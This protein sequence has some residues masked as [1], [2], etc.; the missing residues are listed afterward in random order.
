[1]EPVGRSPWSRHMTRS[2]IEDRA[3]FGIVRYAQCWEDAD[4]LL[5]AL[6]VKPGETCLS[7]ASAGDNCLSLLARDPARVVAID[8]SL[9]QLYCLEL[10]VAAY[11]RLSHEQLLGLM[12]SRHCPDRLRLLEACMPD[13]SGDCAAFWGDRSAAVQKFGLGGIGKFERYFRIFRRWVLPL[14]H[15]KAT[16]DAVLAA[17]DRESRDA[18]FHGTWDSRRWRWL[19]S[20]FFSRF[21]M[22]RLGRDPEFFRYAEGG[23]ARHVGSRVAYA[24]TVLE[25]ETNPYLQWI[26]KGRHVGALP[27]PLRAENFEA[28]RRNLD[29]L[30]YRRQSLEDFIASGEEI[31][32]FNLSDIFEYMSEQAYE[33]LYV[34]LLDCA[35]SGSRI[36]YWNML[37]PRARP[38]SVAHRVRQDP[39]RSSQM[40]ARDK[41]FFYSRFVLERVP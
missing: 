34:R 28:I 3:S 10:R 26:L 8:L 20:I 23:L 11:R 33:S 31:D 32:A 37:A 22:G 39:Q 36:A 35:K 29:R 15:G 9:A 4:V 12:G 41:A 14:V 19:L 25:P 27:F 2:E 21:V 16:V 7:I 17:K 6:D 5:E 18:F 40:H 1:M 13:L 30:D 24:L 38:E